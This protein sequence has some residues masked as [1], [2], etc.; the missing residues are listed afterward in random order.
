MFDRLINREINAEIL[1]TFLFIV[2]SGLYIEAVYG[3]GKILDTLFLWMFPASVMIFLTLVLV[4]I[5]ER[6][7]DRTI[8]RYRYVD[9]RKGK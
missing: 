6:F 8:S 4:K 3:P 1:V 5:I 2:I 9:W 7:H